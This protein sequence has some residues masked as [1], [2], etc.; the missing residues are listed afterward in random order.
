MSESCKTQVEEGDISFRNPREDEVST[1]ENQENF[2]NSGQMF[3]F[4]PLISPLI[5]LPCQRDVVCPQHFFNVDFNKFA[6]T[7][8]LEL[9][10]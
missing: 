9:H 2:S 3:V 7:N 8:T 1:V 10:S 6:N 5:P 4:Y